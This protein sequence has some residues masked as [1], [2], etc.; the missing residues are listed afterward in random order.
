MAQGCLGARPWEEWGPGPSGQGGKRHG[1]DRDRRPR[2]RCNG[3]GEVEKTKG[4]VLHCSL[5]SRINTRNFTEW[6]V[7]SDLTDA[8]VPSCP[9]RPHPY[10][11]V[12]L[13]WALHPRCNLIPIL[14]DR[15]LPKTHLSALSSWR[16]LVGRGP[17]PF[18]GKATTHPSTTRSRPARPVQA[19]WT[20][21]G[22][23]L[24]RAI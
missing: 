20:S 19:P 16:T 12:L 8:V 24:P 18:R 22:T 13:I 11:V 6:K 5:T 1:Q 15:G 2:P 3:M 9:R 4:A 7:K 14:I 21:P 17:G 23:A 10:R